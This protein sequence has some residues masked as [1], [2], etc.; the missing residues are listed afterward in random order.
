PHIEMSSASLTPDLVLPHMTHEAGHLW[1]R[2]LPHEA[3]RDYSRFLGATCPPETVEVTEYAHE[4]FLN[5]L[6]A[7][8][9]GADE[10]CRECRRRRVQDVWTEES[11]GETVAV[12]HVPAHQSRRCDSTV[13]LPARRQA[14]GDI[15]GLRFGSANG[16]PTH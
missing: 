4:H 3:R 6:K 2:T 7:A 12:L 14:I 15:A 5:S 13:N 10:G 1:W 11:F 9:R 16:G 8:T